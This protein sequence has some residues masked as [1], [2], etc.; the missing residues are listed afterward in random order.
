MKDAFLALTRPHERSLF[1]A[2]LRFTGNRADAEDLFQDTFM[3]AFVGFKRSP[4]IEKPRAWFY[5]IMTNAYINEY[6][7][8][9]RRPRRISYDSSLDHRIDSLYTKRNSD[10]AKK[11]FARFLDAQVKQALDSLPVQFRQA[12]ILCDMD[13]YTYEEISRKLDCPLGTVRSRISRGREILFHKL[14][15]YALERGL[16]PKTGVPEGNSRKR[17][18]KGLP[19]RKRNDMPTPVEA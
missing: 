8:K 15:R 3:R 9:R 18:M 12:V 6:N 10:P 13:G 2:A 1:A 5:K 19:S 4:Y 7:R 16:L 17:Y 14:Y 11:F